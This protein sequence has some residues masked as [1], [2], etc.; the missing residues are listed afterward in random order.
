M[1]TKPDGFDQNQP[2]KSAEQSSDAAELR[3]TEQLLKAFAPRAPRLQRENLLALVQAP[4]AL[5]RT[6]WYWPAATAFF[7]ATSLALALVVLLRPA[8]T[9]AAIAPG[10][11]PS[12]PAAAPPIKREPAALAQVE[13]ET[14]P[15]HSYLEY[16]NLA[17]FDGVEAL[18]APA[19]AGGG[20][21]IAPATSRELLQEF[22]P[23]PRLAPHSRM[24]KSFGWPPFLIPNEKM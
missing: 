15:P 10:N 3:Q 12:A 19:F 17:L 18:P 22:V 5:T 14:L 2:L 9:S 1:S 4:V 6:P 7:A 16:R 24:E 13:W 8:S 11:P 20:S 23:G 21:R